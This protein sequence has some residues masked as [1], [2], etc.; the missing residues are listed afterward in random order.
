MSW[1]KG[2]VVMLP[3]KGGE[4]FPILLNT[5]GR[6]DSLH[7]PTENY[8][9]TEDYLKESKFQAQ[10][11]YF[12][13]DEEI[14][15][16]DWIINHGFTTSFVDK[17][18]KKFLDLYN[19]SDICKIIAITDKAITYYSDVE[20]NGFSGD[21]TFP[22]PSKDFIKKWIEEYNKGNKIEEVMVEH[23]SELIHGRLAINPFS[24]KHDTILGMNEEKDMVFFDNSQTPYSIK[25]VKLVNP[26]IKVNETNEINIKTV[27]DSWTREE[28]CVKLREF[29][30]H[31]WKE[32][33]TAMELENWIDKNL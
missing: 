5:N 28:V 32:G 30:L 22:E 33:I 3:I 25:S 14:K 18:E 13:S 4:N 1:I 31:A 15:E 23:D 27:K 10:H 19:H 2:K 7:K 16:G 9:Y 24:G 11:L 21:M 8:Y 29:R 12:L 6:G 17:A 20:I 26:I